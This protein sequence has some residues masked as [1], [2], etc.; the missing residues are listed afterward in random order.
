MGKK[1]SGLKW[2]CVNTTRITLKTK[3]TRNKRQG[4]S[5]RLSCVVL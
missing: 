3:E 1:K 4:G 2:L 5:F